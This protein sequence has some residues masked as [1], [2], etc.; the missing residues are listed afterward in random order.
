MLRL[1]I[2]SSLETKHRASTA[3]QPTVLCRAL[4]MTRSTQV[5]TPDGVPSVPALHGGRD[6]GSSDTGRDA[7]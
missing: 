1:A 7:L 2:G 4:N 5:S 3:L 6:S